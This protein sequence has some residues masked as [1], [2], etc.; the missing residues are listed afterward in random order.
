MIKTIMTRATQSIHTTAERIALENPGAKIAVICKTPPNP[1]EYDNTNIVIY[2][3]TDSTGKVA[4]NQTLSEQRA[5]AV[6]T[7]LASKGLDSN[8]FETQGLGVNDPIAS[9]ETA[10]G[11]DKNRRV[12][13]AIVANETMI[14]SA[15]LEGGN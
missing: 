11:R 6:K 2:G 14:N 4:Y 15:K 3:Y 8:R 1:R 9:N 12:E 5:E 7:Y 10:E 13:F